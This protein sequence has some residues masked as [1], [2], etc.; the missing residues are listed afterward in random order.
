M[1]ALLRS[2]FR[3]KGLNPPAA[4]KNHFIQ[5]YDSFLGRS[6]NDGS[7]KECKCLHLEWLHFRTDWLKLPLKL[8]CSL[9]SP[10]AKSCIYPSLSLPYLLVQECI[11]INSLYVHPLFRLC[12][13]DPLT[14]GLPKNMAS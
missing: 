12:F 7:L 3:T 9:T 6:G 13:S 11:L 4:E 2:H 8:G 1:D 5:S 10:S 14:V